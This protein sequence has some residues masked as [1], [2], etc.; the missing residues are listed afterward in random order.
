TFASAKSWYVLELTC[1]SLDQSAKNI[2]KNATANPLGTDVEKAVARYDY[3]VNKYGTTTYTDFLNRNPASPVSINFSMLKIDYM[4]GG[5]F[6]GII[7]AITL[8]IIFSCKR[9]RRDTE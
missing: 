1:A 3:I 6:L 9:K 5:I 2:L 7:T 8:A 4:L